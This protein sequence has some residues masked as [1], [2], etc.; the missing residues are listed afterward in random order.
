MTHKNTLT[1]HVWKKD[2]ISGSKT[3][4]EHRGSTIFC[5]ETAKAIAE[6]LNETQEDNLLENET[7]SFLYVVSHASKKEIMKNI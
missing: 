4:F 6:A 2:I 5:A 3:L 1:H 7:I